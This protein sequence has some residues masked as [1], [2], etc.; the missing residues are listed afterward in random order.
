MHIYIK[1]VVRLF[2]VSTI[3]KL[4]YKNDQV[5][6]FIAT[7]SFIGTRKK[8]SVSLLKRAMRVIIMNMK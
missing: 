6:V 8:Q 4:A 3:G 5:E 2:S 1:C 7:E